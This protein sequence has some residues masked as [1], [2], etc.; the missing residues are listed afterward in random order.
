MFGS[1]G[2]L[3]IQSSVGRYR[4]ADAMCM[5]RDFSFLVMNGE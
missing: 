3:R 5:H 4:P 1:P 2:H